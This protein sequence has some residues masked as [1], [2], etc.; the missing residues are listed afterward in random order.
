[1]ANWRDEYCAA[2]A[3]RDEAEKANVVL[4]DACPYTRSVY[5]AHIA[6]LIHWADT[7]LADRTSRTSTGSTQPAASGSSL[8]S[9]GRIPKIP[10]SN[11]PATSS[12]AD[13]LAATRSDLSEAQRS[14]AE[15]QDR[16]AR[17]TAE[18]EKIRKKNV[19]DTRRITVLEGE[20]THLTLRLKDRDEELKGKAKLLEVRI[21]R[22]CVMPWERV[23][24]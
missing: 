2:L 19:Q 6:D 23:L 18:L 13:L 8:G 7:R 14:R 21:W 9:S 4:Y 3:V 16:L 20:R 12:L 15:L 5:F 11:E 17:T 22:S 24:D 1:M 10:S